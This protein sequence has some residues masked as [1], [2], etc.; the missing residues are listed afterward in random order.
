M[1]LFLKLVFATLISALIVGCNLDVPAITTA[2]YSLAQKNGAEESIQL[3]NM[4]T[5]QISTWLS[6]HRSGWS[7]SFVTY[8]PKHYISGNLVGGKYASFNIWTSQ[9][10][11]VIDSEQYMRS[12]SPA[13]SASIMSILQPSK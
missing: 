12:L 1:Q 3:S 13:E 7:R 11:A 5:Q 8:V 6:A 4:Q 2:K 9:I 10:V